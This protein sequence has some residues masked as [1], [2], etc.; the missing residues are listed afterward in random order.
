MSKYQLWY[1]QIIW[2]AK[3]RQLNC[4]SEWHHILPRSLGGGDED[5]NLVELTYR[6]HFLAHWLLTKIHTEGRGRRAMV[7]ALMC[8]GTVH[9]SSQRLIASWQFEIAKRSIKNHVIERKRLLKHEPRL[10]QEL[11]IQKH[12]DERHLKWKN[13]D[14]SK[15]DVTNTR[16]QDTLKQ[17]ASKLLA[18]IKNKKMHIPLTKKQLSHSKFGKLN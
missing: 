1:D 13:S 5:K 8:M 16:H 6:E 2:R 12:K 9:P 3:N 17:A 7:Y 11:R 10:D 18:P 15:L 4:Y 14:I